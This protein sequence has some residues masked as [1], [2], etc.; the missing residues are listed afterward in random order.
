MLTLAA[1]VQQESPADATVSAR[2]R[3]ILNSDPAAVIEA[4]TCAA[5]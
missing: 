2:W 5:T 1:P 3:I 4:L